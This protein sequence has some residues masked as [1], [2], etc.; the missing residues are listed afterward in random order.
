MS[1]LQY[2][3][4]F[5]LIHN[6]LH[7]SGFSFTILTNEGNLLSSFNCKI[8][9]VQHHMVAIPFSQILSLNRNTTRMRRWWKFQMKCRIVFL[10]HLDDVHLLQLFDTRLNLVGL[11][12][13]I[14]ESFDEI[15]CIL[16]L[17]L[18]IF[19]STQLLFSSLFPQFHIFRIGDFII[20]N[21]AKRDLDGTSRHII[22]EG[23]IVGN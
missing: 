12:S 7:Q 18:L 10:I 5:H 3:L 14:A 17:F 23:S 19:V 21:F 20:I 15:L 16:N 11:S 22:N 9:R 8:N 13:F 2:T 4:I 6:T 1:Q